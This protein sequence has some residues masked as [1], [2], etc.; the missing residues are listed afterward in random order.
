[1]INEMIE[2]VHYRATYNKM[3]Y[4]N[5]A[6]FDKS[7]D[8]KLLHVADDDLDSQMQ[9]METS[10]SDGNASPSESNQPKMSNS[11]I[12]EQAMNL[13]QENATITLKPKFRQNNLPRKDFKFQR[14]VQNKAVPSKII[15]E[16]ESDDELEAECTDT[17]PSAYLQ[18]VGIAKSLE[19]L[20][21]KLGK[22]THRESFLPEGPAIVHRRDVK[23]FRK[24]KKMPIAKTGNNLLD[25]LNTLDDYPITTTKLNDQVHFPTNLVR[26]NATVMMS[27]YNDCLYI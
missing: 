2:T 7:F 14:T 10:D 22:R 4:T 27:S 20:E 13:M 21:V 9:T 25:F 24:A 15:V 16:A 18:A 3:A 23:R 8:L 17:S 12:F 6:T 11:S 5:V 1:M 26:M 19:N